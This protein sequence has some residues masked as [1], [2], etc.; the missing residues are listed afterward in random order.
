MPLTQRSKAPTF[1]GPELCFKEA[2]EV[3]ALLKAGEVSPQ[4]LLQ[5][6]Y[7]RIASVEPAVNAMPIL[8]PDRAGAAADALPSGAPDGRGWLAGMPVAIKDLTPVA[9]V[10]CTWGT[11][12]MAD[13][14]AE[15][16][17]PL[18]ARI[19]ANGGIVIGKTNTPEFGAGGNTFNAVFGKTRNPYDTTMNA[20][21]SSGGAA[22]SLATG[23]VWLSHGSDHGGSLRTP[24]AYNGIVGLRPSPG[25]CASDSEIG[26]I[27][28]GQQ[29]PMARSV[30][31]C[32]LFLDAMAGFD[33]TIPSSFPAPCE[34]SYE[35]AVIAAPDAVRIAFSP[36]LGGLSPVEPVIDGAI[37]DA[38]RAVEKNGGVIEE[39]TP[40]LTALEPTYHTLRGLLWASAFKRA[41]ESLT[42]HFKPTLAEN[43]AFG[44]ALTID[45]ITEAQLNRTTL[46]KTMT[47]LLGDFDV[48][49]CPVVGN[50]PRPVDVEWVDEVNGVRF[51]GYMDWLRFAFLATTT[52]LPAISVPI[53]FDDTGMPL[54]IQLIGPH[55]GESRLLSVARAVERAVGGPFP[56]IDPRVTHKGV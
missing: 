30:R 29:G 11:R 36:D 8:C 5:A 43:T 7:D 22:V 13:N 51:D 16:S 47:A 45:D 15:K 44:Q 33:P 12:A 50:M 41:P 56:P 34:G 1:S 18:V 49:A 52:G 53:G 3:V 2:H 20:A 42:R 55:R 26:F 24:A 31:D 35:Q 28:E 38:L 39:V 6:A 23:E 14:V 21:G 40:D 37:R 9:G 54:A 46:F 19:E 10:L 32:A 25:L 48:L 4:D 27:T 17:D